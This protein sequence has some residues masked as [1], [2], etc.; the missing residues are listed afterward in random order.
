LLSGVNLSGGEYNA[1]SSR[2]YWDYVYPSTAEIDYYASK[3]FK[4]LRIPILCDRMLLNQTSTTDA[5]IIYNLILYA[6]KYSMKIIIDVHQFGYMD[7]GLV[8]V[9]PSATAAF[10][11]F[12][13]TMA[14]L[15]KSQSNVIFGL[16]NEP[17]AQSATE[18]VNAANAAIAAIRQAGA[19]QLILVSGSYWT[20]AW[21]WTSTNNSGV[22]PSV[23]DPIKNFAFEVH[24]YLDFDGSGTHPTVVLGSGSSRLVDFTNWA[25]SYRF[26]GFLG[27][28]GFASNPSAMQEGQ[29][30]LAYMSK[31]SDVWLGWSYWA[32]GPWVGNYM[33]SVEPANNVD[34]PQMQVLSQYM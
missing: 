4:A 14:K 16:M 34:K 26:K 12:W 24:Q 3:G 31:N 15:L 11:A 22:M 20:G 8:G 18:W 13:G 28:F 21:T 30:L 32:G 17:N 10:V 5:S 7:Q 33:F 6:Q 19:S 27:E 2:L 29:N 23:I 1:G 9:T 25:R